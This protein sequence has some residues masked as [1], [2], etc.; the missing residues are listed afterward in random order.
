MKRL[1]FARKCSQWTDD[2][3]RKV[4]SFDKSKINCLGSNGHEW[5]WKTPRG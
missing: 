4:L 1:N 3:W 2:N 5:V